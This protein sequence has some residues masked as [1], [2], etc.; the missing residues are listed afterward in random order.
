[1]RPHAGSNKL[2]LDRPEPP[3]ALDRRNA[4]GGSLGYRE[5]RRILADQK[6]SQL[7]EIMELFLSSL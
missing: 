6:E 3:T 2:F 5:L 1:M 7:S 4:A